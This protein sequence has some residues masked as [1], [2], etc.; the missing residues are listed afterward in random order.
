MEIPAAILTT[1]TELTSGETV[2]TNAAWVAEKLEAMGFAV[3]AHISVPDDKK[4]IVDA[5]EWLKPRAR[6]VIVGGG[7]GP[8]SDDLTREAVAAWSGAEL[9]FSEGV[10]RELNDRYRQ[11]GL[12]IRPAH[13]QQCY[14]PKTS[15]T[16]TN[17][18]G[19]ALG[20]ALDARG[21]RL[22]V[23]PGPPREL[24]GMW[25]PHVEP[26]LQEL[27]PRSETELVVWTCEG[28]TES[29]L[30]EVAEAVIAGSGLKIGYRAS[31]PQVKVKLWL[32]RVFNERE[33]WV[34]K[35]DQALRE[36]TV[37]RIRS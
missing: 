24:Q 7:L 9:E 17:P 14:F 10:W 3:A 32:P 20:F 13:R 26:L 1:G 16:I 4:L 21:V 19:S 15:R 35:M 18:V 37:A 25:E 23:L 27:G 30:A 22:A 6:L 36:W 2:N 8:T 33:K 29:R 34:E 5:L 28:A 12:K 31:V 11:R